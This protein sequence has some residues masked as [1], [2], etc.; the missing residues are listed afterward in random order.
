VSGK[1]LMMDTLNKS[2]VDVYESAQYCSPMEFNRNALREL[3]KY[4]SFD[5]CVLADLAVSSERKVVVQNLYLEA[6]PVERLRDRIKTVGQETLQQNGSLHSQDMTLVRA[7]RQRGESVIADITAMPY[8]PQTLSYCRKYETAHSLAFVSDKT[9]DSAVPTLGLW[10]AG[11]RDS[12]SA[13]HAHD[14]TLFLPHLIQAREINRRLKPNVASPPVRNRLMLATLDG[15]LC[16]TDNGAIGLLQSEWKEWTPPFLPPA[17][18]AGLQSSSAKIFSGKNITVQARICEN[19]LYLNVSLN[20][21]QHERLTPAELRVAM[22][23][24]QGFQYKEIARHI[25]VAPA[26]IR[27]QLHSVYRKLGVSNKTELAAVLAEA[28]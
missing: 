1:S 27:N 12:Y 8:D 4:V 26:T 3:K 9:F 25:V 24:A 11:K 2:L 22:L 17:L 23:A 5:S 7:F 14:A 28:S 6:T 18:L 13:K 19:T 20:R 21:N 15:Q 16:F 10:R